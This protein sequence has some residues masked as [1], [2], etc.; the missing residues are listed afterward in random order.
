VTCR[1]LAEEEDD[2]RR[3]GWRTIE[4]GQ[5]PDWFVLEDDT[6]SIVVDPDGADLVLGRDYRNIEMA[7]G[8]LGRRRRYTEW[9]LHPGETACVVG[10]VR[11]VRS[12][13]SLRG[14]VVAQSPRP[15]AVRRVGFRVNLRV[16]R[17]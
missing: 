4:S 15:G 16:G 2:D 3:G 17:R 7:H 5:S 6:G 9:R 11:R 14:R 1:F 12:R 10:T 8:W 13:R